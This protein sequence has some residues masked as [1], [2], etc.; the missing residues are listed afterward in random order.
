MHIIRAALVT[1][2]IF[3]ILIK[4]IKASFG[5]FATLRTGRSGYRFDPYLPPHK[6]NQRKLTTPVPQPIPCIQTF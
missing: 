3:F 1:P 4:L 2:G 5:L 6:E